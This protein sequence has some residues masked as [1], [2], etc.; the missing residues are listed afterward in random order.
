[1][2]ET[3]ILPALVLGGV[4]LLKELGILV[5][6]VLV[7]DWLTEGESDPEVSDADGWVADTYRGLWADRYWALFKVWSATLTGAALSS[8][9]SSVALAAKAIKE[10]DSQVWE[11]GLIY[12]A[13]HAKAE[14]LAAVSAGAPGWSAVELL[15]EVEFVGASMTLDVGGDTPP[16]S[17]GL[18]A[19]GAAAVAAAWWWFR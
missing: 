14:K 7:A 5:G 17:W 1:M 4:A 15:P 6:A 18:A 11:G 2:R 12:R 3:G 9:K 13:L 8:L 10:P 19:L 16:P